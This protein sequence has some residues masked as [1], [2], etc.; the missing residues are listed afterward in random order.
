MT[1][2]F[3]EIYQNPGLQLLSI[4]LGVLIFLVYFGDRGWLE[5]DSISQ[6]EGIINFDSRGPDNV[7]AYY[8]QPLSYELNRC[9]FSVFRNPRFFYYLPHVAGALVICLLLV[10]MRIHSRQK[11]GFFMSLAM[12]FLL[13]ELFYSGLYFN[14]S[15]FSMLPIAVALILLV[16]KSPG[17]TP[18]D[19]W[20]DIRAL[21]IGFCAAL[22]ALFRF[23]FLLSLPM[24]IYLSMR[25]S[26][27]KIRSAAMVATGFI[28]IFLLS[29]PMGLFDLET[30]KDVYTTYQGKDSEAWPGINSFAVLLSLMSPPVW[31]LLAVFS[32]C[33]FWRQIRSGNLHVLWILI[34][35]AI[36]MYPVPKLL[37]PKYLV[38]MLMFLPLVFSRIFTGF[39]QYRNGKYARQAAVW[40]VGCSVL[41]QMISIEPIMDFPNRLYRDKPGSAFPYF[42]IQPVPSYIGTHDGPRSLGAF[43]RGY[44]M[45]RQG[46]D[47]PKFRAMSGHRIAEA[48]AGWNAD[49][50]VIISGRENN[51]F[52]GDLRWSHL[53]N[54]IGF[55]QMDG[56]RLL[57]DFMD[58]RSYQL[59]KG[60]HKIS[61]EI[62]DESEYKSYQP[63]SDRYL[64]RIPYISESDPKAWEKVQTFLFHMLPEMK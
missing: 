53:S 32:F 17:R 62:L 6:I 26:D 55:L 41:L 52:L 24:F 39:Q 8:W 2:F 27:R 19:R 18:A 50:T 46:R 33:Y 37:S 34:P 3:K 63:E 4:F 48:A 61:V 15:V 31:I 5:A 16:K 1:G 13:P 9:L 14:S 51:C 7:Y 43:Y 42:I 59:L 30:F 20:G 40:V 54:L 49:V 35:S 11:M 12:L 21:A 22:A 47:Y 38:P 25:G 36:L 44:L 58:L 28:V 23:D 64:L 57:T 45:V 29:I 56:Y 60:N 10:A